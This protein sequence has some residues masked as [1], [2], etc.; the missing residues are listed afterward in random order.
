MPGTV[1]NNGDIGS[2]MYLQVERYLNSAHLNRSIFFLF[3]LIVENL[4]NIEIISKINFKNYP[5]CA[6]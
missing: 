5:E 2:Y 3:S 4:A 1:L 6:V